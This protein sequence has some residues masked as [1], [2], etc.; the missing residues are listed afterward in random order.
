MPSG[1]GQAEAANIVE[2]WRRQ[3]TCT[4]EGI[5]MGQNHGAIELL[6]EEFVAIGALLACDPVALDLVERHCFGGDGAFPTKTEDLIGPATDASQLLLRSALTA[7]ERASNATI[8]PPSCMTLKLARSRSVS[9]TLSVS[10]KS[11]APA[12]LPSSSL[13]W[14]PSLNL[15][16]A[17][18]CRCRRCCCDCRTHRAGSCRLPG[19]GCLQVARYSHG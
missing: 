16:R 7:S 18:L 6:E 3:E 8:V 10:W 9:R 14:L 13:P 15:C 11:S 1:S 2:G 5:T 17:R 4:V 12:I 19:P